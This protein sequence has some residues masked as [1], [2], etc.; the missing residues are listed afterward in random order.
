[1]QIFGHIDMVATD[2][3]ASFLLAAA[4]QRVKRKELVLRILDQM[5]PNLSTAQDSGQN[6]QQGVISNDL[7]VGHGTGSDQTDKA[8]RH[9]HVMPHLQHQLQRLHTPQDGSHQHEVC[10]TSV[11]D[12]SAGTGHCIFSSVH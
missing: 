8:E 10:H 12:P 7:Y 11:L 1:M 2:T 6:M 3:L 5:S 4:A 9:I